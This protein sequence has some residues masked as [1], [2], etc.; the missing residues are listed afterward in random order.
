M[1]KKWM[2]V[3]RDKLFGINKLENKLKIQQSHFFR[4]LKAMEILKPYFPAGYLFESGFS[5]SFQTIQHIANDLVVYKPKFMLEFG[6]GMST[7]ILNNFI[8]QNGLEVKLISID[9]D[10]L[11]QDF[12]KEKCTNVDFF[13]FPLV[14]N[15]PF[16]FESN[17]LWYDIP[18]VHP[19]NEIK[20]DLILV[21]APKGSL[22][23]LSRFG[24]I[25]F[26]ENR[27]S[28]KP[29]IYLDDTHRADEQKISELFLSR[30]FRNINSKQFYNYTRFS[31]N[32]T[33]YTS[34][35]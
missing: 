19:L 23:R 16:S 21:D 14:Q 31:S 22:S 35:S 30:S 7:I 4:E 3:V 1:I 2:S 5:L 11:W 15:H 12:L 10:V 34:P 9:D 33:Y 8:K 13:C 24:F 26:L 6:S 17:G 18:D 25:P 27:L 29:I 20:Y 28:E 32:D